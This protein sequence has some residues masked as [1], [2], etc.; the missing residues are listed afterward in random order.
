M[1]WR[2]T[3]SLSTILI[4]LT[5]LTPGELRAS[6]RDL[7]DVPDKVDALFFVVLSDDARLTLPPL[8]AAM[9]DKPSLR[10]KKTPP[11]AILFFTRSTD[12]TTGNVR[13]IEKQHRDHTAILSHFGLTIADAKPGIF[14]IDARAAKTA[15]P[16]HSAALRKFL[17]TFDAIASRGHVKTLRRGSTGIGYTLETLLG[18]EENNSKTGDF[19]GMELKAHRGH[20]FAKSTSRRMN[21]FLKEPRWTD[22]L[23]HSQRIKAYGYRDDNGRQA[24][25]ST[26]T[27]KTNS[28]GLQLLVQSNAKRVDLQFK[29]KTI[30]NWTY[31]ILSQRL[32]E[33]LKETAF[34]GAAS[35]GIPSDETFHYQT[36]LY[37]HEPS[38][39]SLVSLINAGHVMV[40]MRMHV[41]ED[42]KARNHGTAFRVHQNRL[43]MLFALT[44]KC[45]TGN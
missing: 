22:G 18:I 45:R 33:K 30:A 9:I 13:V 32:Q 1:Q 44:V 42:G 11:G 38:V 34:I 8:M 40:E 2:Q 4:S 12:L 17:P 27:H 14:G 6:I 28:H 26:V 19:M 10:D 21:L 7:L 3:H 16:I 20:D 31:D 5:L 35:K 25:Y 36:V 43:P 39:E 24:L 15:N 41:K 23:P 29:E 37:C